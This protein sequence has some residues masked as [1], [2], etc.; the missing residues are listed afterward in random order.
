MDAGQ[1]K[2]LPRRDAEIF[3]VSVLILYL[4]LVLIR[5]IG[6]EVRLFAYLGNLILVVCFFGVGIGCYLAAQPVSLLRMS[7]HL[8]VLAVLVANPLHRDELNL[9]HATDWLAGFEDS[10]LWG[11]LFQSFRWQ[12]G[13]GLLVVSAVLYLV[14]FTFQPAGQLLG[15]VLQ[16]YPHVLRAY[17]VNIAGS[18]AGIWLFNAVSYWTLPPVVWFGL[19]AAL[20]AALCWAAQERQWW[21][22]VL[23]VAVT[24]VVWVGEP[25]ALL[26][27]WSPYQKLVVEPVVQEY[28]GERLVLGYLISANRT[29][30]QSVV[31]LSEA[32][33]ESKP[34]LLDKAHARLSHYNMAF[35]FQ[36]RVRRALIVGA[37]AG[38]NAAAALRHG[39]EQVDCVE[40]DPDIYLLGKALHPERPYD[41]PHVR[42]FINDAR[43]FFKQATGA[44]DLIWFGLLDTHPGSSYNNR[45][46][47][48]YVYTRESFEEARRLLAPDGVLVINFAARREWI[49]DRLDGML[50]EVFGHEPLA[51]LEGDESSLYSVSG[52]LTLV[53]GHTPVQS[54]VIR[55]RAQFDFVETHRVRLAGSAQPTTDDWPYLYLEHRK[56]PKLH[57]VTSLTVVV[58]VAVAGGRLSVT[59][60]RMD[61]HFFALGAAFLLLEVQ[62]VSRAT[63]LFGMTW[64]VNAIVISAVLLMILLANLTADR[65]PRL[66]AW[67]PVAGL[68]VTVLGLAC[69]PLDS[70]NALRGAPKVIAASGFLTAP[71]F[72]SGLIFIRSFAACADRSRA[73]GSNLIG[74]LV[75]GLL[76]SLSFVT[77]IRALVLL[78][79]LLYAVAL[80]LRPGEYLQTRGE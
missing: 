60:L 51:Y 14:V 22:V 27:L 73:L 65:W 40:I 58:A 35:G 18:L 78:V 39:V 50:R 37:G 54:T 32:F 74:A 17:S 12:M 68:A 9:Q 20:L 34:G 52:E 21:S 70:F 36:P 57:L 30:F 67:L 63:L 55:D 8:T 28:R 3:L 13:L 45:R 11:G 15:R 49:A 80:W 29:T 5:W 2:S 26:T 59:K 48:H 46:L 24:G 16:G 4:E 64:V 75:G 62:T 77:G 61:W 38:N 66:P 56:I 69:V 79:G 1:D 76:E 10:P 42:M 44:Y 25:S 47:D 41:S 7:L 72:F 53:T 71:I 31:N 19:V 43:A 33:L 23:A 6:T